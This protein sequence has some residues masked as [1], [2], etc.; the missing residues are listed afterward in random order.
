MFFNANLVQSAI[1][2][3]KGSIAFI[4][5]YTAWV[6]G[7]EILENTRQLQTDVVSKLE[8]WAEDSGA[9]F[10]PEKTVLIHFTQNTRKI[11]AEMALP[12]A[13]KIGGQLIYGQNE[14]KL[15]GVV[16]DKKLTYKE[17]IAKVLKRGIT[18]AL[19]LKRLRNLHPKSTRQL[20]KS[21]VAPLV[22]YASVIWSPGVGKSTLKKL[23]QIQRIGAQAITGAFRT[24]ALDCRDRSWFTTYTITPISPTT[25][26]L[27]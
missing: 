20:F 12:P 22:D 8:S 7:L 27:G 11:S 4:N 14:V 13:L 2:K 10:N 3:N 23:D 16:F 9:I 6:T 18:A 21:T 19:S 24:V 5:D 25:G 15:L 26:Y 17:H 1:N